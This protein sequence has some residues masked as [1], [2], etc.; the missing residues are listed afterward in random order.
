M[1]RVSVSLIA[2]DLTAIQSELADVETAD[3][4]HLDLMDGHFVPNI[5]LGLPTLDDVLAT[6]DWPTDVHLMTE[7]PSEYLADLDDA[8]AD[9]LTVHVEAVD[10]LSRFREETAGV[11]TELGV[12][13]NPDTP[14]DR[15][16]G[17]LDTVDRVVV[18]GVQPGFSG[19]TFDPDVLPKVRQIAAEA[20]ITVVVDG[21]VS[22]DNAAACVD[23][24]AD[25]LVS[26]SSVFGA[27]DRREAISRLRSAGEA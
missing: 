24:G 27:D 26:G 25:V 21:G 17:W 3:R 16:D 4:L 22:A 18:M 11:S 1:V 12:A 23:A 9:S 13:I 14:V 15:L 10:D 6:T 19:Q 2:S 20:G 7:T 8:G 5:T